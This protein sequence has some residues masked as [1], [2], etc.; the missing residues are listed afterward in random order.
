MRILTAMSGGVDSSVAAFLLR[1]NGNEVVGAMM[2]LFSD[3]ALGELS[4]EENSR[5]CCTLSDADDARAVATR[6]H[7]PF[8][9]F[10]FADVFEATVMRRFVGEYLCGRTPNPCIDCNRFMKFEKFLY[11]AQELDCAAIATGHYARITREPCGRFLLRMGKDAAKDQSY[12]LYTLTQTQLAHT[13]FPLGD[14]EKHEV[15]SIAEEQQFVTARKRD[16]QDICFAPNGD[17]AGFITR[18]TGTPPQKGNFVDAHGN[19]LG[20]HRGIIN[21]TVGQRKGLGISAPAPLFVTKINPPDN[22]VTLGASETLFAKTLTARDI[23]LIAA[24]KID[25]T[26]QV[27]AKIRYAHAPQPAKIH[28]TAPD[29]IRVEFNEPQRAIT[30]GQAVVFYD[31]DV[32]VGGGVIQ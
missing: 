24:D 1:E 13:R 22:T 11:R 9:V 28:Q 20:E 10:N 17:Y 2:K 30:P 32:V 21:Y 4:P 25:G 3:E 6:M 5:A 15:R 8:Y 16:S 29:E 27:Q 7:I 31:S 26:L 12:V 14:L 19:V 18:Q 23:N